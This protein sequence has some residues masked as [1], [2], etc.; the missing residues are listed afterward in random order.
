M[1][2]KLKRL[3]KKALGFIPEE[4]PNTGI[5]FDLWVE[6]LLDL[7]GFRQDDSYKEFLASAIMHL[8]HRVTKVSKRTFAQTLTRQIAN[9]VAYGKIEQM[10]EKAKQKQSEATVPEAAGELVR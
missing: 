10:R 9:R 7:Y 5:D 1:K 3:I 6:E 4:L 8:D 2:Q